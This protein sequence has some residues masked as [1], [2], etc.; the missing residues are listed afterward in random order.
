MSATPS[1]ITAAD[2]YDI[3]F[4]ASCALD[5][6]D[7]MNPDPDCSAAHVVPRTDAD[8]GPEGHAAAPDPAAERAA[9]EARRP[10][11]RLVPAGVTTAVAYSA[12]P[13]SGATTGTALAVDGGTRGLRPRREAR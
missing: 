3:R 10:T 2:T 7:A 5:G 11:G 1:R 9:P 12:S 13:P 4:P 6:S 8:D